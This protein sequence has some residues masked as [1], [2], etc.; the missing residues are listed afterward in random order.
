MSCFRFI[1]W[2]PVKILTHFSILCSSALFCTSSR[3]KKQELWTSSST[4]VVVQ[5]CPHNGGC[6]LWPRTPKHCSGDHLSQQHTNQP[7]KS[8]RLFGQPHFLYWKQAITPSCTHYHPQH[9]AE[10]E[11]LH[12]P[13]SG[14]FFIVPSSCCTFLLTPVVVHP[15]PSPASSSSSN[16]PPLPPTIP[17]SC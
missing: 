8:P 13:P 17:V 11:A 4:V 15:L 10:H 9:P 2:P 12:Q 1:L 3:Q 7:P 14:P 16:P 6:H 5:T